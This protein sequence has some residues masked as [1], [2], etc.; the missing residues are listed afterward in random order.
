[1][2]WS[3]LYAIILVAFSSGF[4]VLY[5]NHRAAVPDGWQGFDCNRVDMGLSSVWE[6]ARYLVEV[7]LNGGAD[8]TCF[9]NSSSDSGGTLILVISTNRSLAF[10]A[11]PIVLL[12]IHGSKGDAPVQFFFSVFTI[13]VLLNVRPLA[14]FEFESSAHN[15]VRRNGESAA[16][17][18]VS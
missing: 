10:T 1:M 5:R 4:Y 17:A 13:V 6:A 15:C 9:R 16:P 11:V 3:I 14:G 8:W 7:T 2:L 18:S 12:H